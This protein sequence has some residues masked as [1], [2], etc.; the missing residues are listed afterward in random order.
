M[1]L[2]YTDENRKDIG[3]IP[4]F[5]WDMA[6]GYDE[7]DFELKISL[8][9]HCCDIGYFL[10]IDGTEYGGIIDKIEV[11]TEKKQVTYS[12]RTWHGILSSKV[13]GL[14]LTPDEYG[15]NYRYSSYVVSGDAND[16]IE[17]IINRV[18]LTDIFEAESENS[19]ITIV[20]NS[21]NRYYDAYKATLNLLNSYHAKLKFEWNHTTQK[22]KLWAE[23][24]ID[25]TEL[26]D[27]DSTQFDFK[28]GKSV[29]FTNHVICYNT[30][31]MRAIHVFAD[32]NGL[33]QP[34][35]RYTNPLKDSD[36]IFDESHK[37]ID[38]L[39]EIIDVL[40]YSDDSVVE[41]YE[42]IHTQPSNWILDHDQYYSMNEDGEYDSLEPTEQE[43]F[44]LLE[45]EPSDWS[46]NYKNYYYE[47][48]GVMKNVEPQEGFVEV[49]TKPDNWDNVYG[50]YFKK[51]GNQYVQMNE[52]EL[53]GTYVP[54]AKKPHNWSKQYEQYYYF[55]GLT[56]Q[57]ISGVSKNSYDD[58]KA[59]PS[60]WNQVYGNYYYKTHIWKRKKSKGKWHYYK[61]KEDY[62]SAD[63]Y[64]DQKTHEE[65]TRTKAPKWQLKKYYA[66]NSYTI[67]P[68]F[69]KNQF[70]ELKESKGAPSWSGTTYYKLVSETAP[71]WQSGTYYK[72]VSSTVYTPFKADT[73]F[74]KVEDH[75]SEMIAEAIELIEES[76]KQTQSVDIDFDSSEYYDI[77]DT[78]G[79][80]EQHT[81]L[82]IRETITKKIVKL[83]EKSE[84]ITYETSNK[85][86]MF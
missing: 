84:K 14:N 47:D 54:L 60:N 33:I 74:R 17:E 24:S 51:V 58:L 19:G 66:K 18:G 9:R 42:L 31:T 20:Q 79:A 56:Y 69:I 71:A 30:L 68:K 37:A 61:D 85:Y 62:L 70:Y 77:L 8:K 36:Y 83:T 32:E 46:R 29:A 10:Y 22:V 73:Y 43:E 67:A 50:N 15:G 39:N 64:F 34:Y 82:S 76:Y 65:K 72:L 53:T 59:K 75:Y 57:N 52:Y 78:V 28:V 21:L 55:D 3:V 25:H 38:G 80:H 35:A 45:S 48:A 27:F 41:N 44:R 6:Y 12:G 49:Q 23:I 40:E 4:F 13:I 86:M 5:E 81:G 7:N 26:D 1:D 16:V 11:D 63:K 2:I